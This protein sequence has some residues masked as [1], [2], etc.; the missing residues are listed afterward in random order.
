MIGSLT[1]VRFIVILFPA[2]LIIYAIMAFPESGAVGLFFFIPFLGIRQLASFSLT[3]FL[4]WFIKLI[5]GKRI[6]KFDALDVTVIFF[7]IA[8]LFGGFFSVS[9]SESTQLAYILLSMIAG[10]FAVS[11]LLRT[12]SW[13]KKCSSALVI[14]FAVSLLLC[15]I[16]E[17]AN[18]IPLSQAKSIGAMIT[19]ATGS[20]STV[21]PTFIHMAVAVIP[22]MLCMSLSSRMANKRSLT[23]FA[24][25]ASLFCLYT[26]GSRSGFTCL[27]IGTLILLM[28]TSKK[29]LAYII[30]AVLIIPAVIALL[31]SGITSYVVKLFSF[32][33]SIASYR[34]SI[35]FTTNKIMSDSFF[36]GIGLGDAAMAK[37]F[38]LYANDTSLGI[39]HA[40]NLYSQIIV[41]LGF[42]GLIILLAFIIQLIRDY[43]TYNSGSANDDPAL[44]LIAT[45]TFAGLS[46]LL[47]MG[48]IDYIWYSPSVF[49]M[50]WLMTALFR[51]SVRTAVSERYEPIPD[52][53]TLEL[54][55]NSLNHF[56]KR[57]G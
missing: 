29:S 8:I 23:I 39:T 43:F 41:S 40:S 19:D 42:T 34:Q 3:V 51:A 10:Y 47:I 7:A 20:L 37:I 55:C 38:P 46:A 14:S 54:D 33:G 6:F 17:A 56:S 28:L 48:L 27:I 25:I 57:K 44:K 2:L 49:L 1:S 9:P 24:L 35:N 16:S 5:R 18:I 13:I 32:D 52:G 50:F 22:I 45:S 36:G 30:P 12:A 53:P 15:F 26:G 31:P 21:G 11:N 4:S